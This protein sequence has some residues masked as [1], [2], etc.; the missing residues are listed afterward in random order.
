[1]P[2][3]INLDDLLSLPQP[4]VLIDVRKAPA[5]SSSGRTIPD[6][7]RGEPERATE[8]GLAFRGRRVVVFCVHGHEVSQGVADALTGL[9]I[10]A[11]YLEGGFAAWEAAGNPVVAIGARP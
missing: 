5:R 4:P 6:A 3:P 9:G 2:I 8:W 7:E 10:D 11:A 1:M